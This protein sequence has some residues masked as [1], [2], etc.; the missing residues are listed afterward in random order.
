MILNFL[1]KT[2]VKGK[3]HCRLLFLCSALFLSFGSERLLFGQT[4]TPNLETG[5]TLEPALEIGITG[6]T[7]PLGK[8]TLFAG[9]GINFGTISFTHPERISNGDAY[10]K[11]NLLHLEAIMQVSVTFNGFDSVALELKKLP[12]GGNS[13]HQS[14]YSL[15]T[16]R[17]VAPEVI[18]EDPRN[19]RVQ[20]L[21]QS[22]ETLL[23]LVLEMTPRQKGWVRDGFRL[24]ARGL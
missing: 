12:S 10:L 24:E 5:V 6:G 19:N 3:L 21:T 20:T 1:T 16:Q 8:K 7:N 11:N 4:S 17:E 22:S 2:S 18:F 14:S 23:R 13:F 9:G 15:S